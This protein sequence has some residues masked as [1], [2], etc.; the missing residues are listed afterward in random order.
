MQDHKGRNL[1]PI[2]Y[3]QNHGFMRQLLFILTGQCQ[4]EKLR[5]YCPKE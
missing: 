1:H 4:D 5:M 3:P 2:R